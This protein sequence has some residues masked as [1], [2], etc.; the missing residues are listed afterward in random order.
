MGKHVIVKQG[1]LAIRNDLKIF[2]SELSL[3]FFFN[4]II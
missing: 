2:N 3:F 1:I 4:K